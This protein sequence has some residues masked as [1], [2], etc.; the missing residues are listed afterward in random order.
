MMEMNILR[1]LGS[2]SDNLCYLLLFLD[3]LILYLYRKVRRMLPQLAFTTIVVKLDAC[4]R[5]QCTLH[6]YSWNLHIVKVVIYGAS[7]LVHL[8]KLERT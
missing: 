7:C 1:T 3:G 4:M 2:V 6:I 8:S 5:D